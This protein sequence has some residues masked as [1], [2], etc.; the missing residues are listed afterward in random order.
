M[1]NQ[2]IFDVI[3]I[4]GGI[5]GNAVADYI[6]Q[7]SKLK[8]LLLEQN[9]L[10]TGST[11]FSASLVTKLR[12]ETNLIPFIEETHHAVS[13]LE[14]VHGESLGERR[15]GCLHVA[16][17]SDS[18]KELKKLKLIADESGI[19][20]QTVD[21]EFIRDRVPWMVSEKVKDALFVPDEFFIDG[22]LL[23]M[24][25]FK[26][27][28]LNGL[29]Y[30]T[31]CK[32]IRIISGNNK[33]TGVESDKGIYSAPIIIDTAGIWTNLLLKEHDVLLPYAPVRSLYFITEVNI[34]N[35]PVS[36]PICIL[37]DANAFSRPET[38]ALLIGLR[39]SQSPWTHPA[40]IQKDMSNQKSITQNEQWNILI[41]ETAGLSSIMKDFEHLK[42]AHAIAAPCAY[43]HDGNP[44]L[45][46]VKQLEGLFVAT[47]CNGAGISTSAGFGRVIAEI[48]LGK[49]PFVSINDY[50]PARLQKSHPFSEEFMQKCSAR[51]SR[52]KSG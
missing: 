25:F 38:G 36:Q 49:E 15:V 7:N 39:D 3:I 19:V 48:V 28:R 26:S 32:V 17:D 10:C 5:L 47:G 34:E 21:K 33:I 37:P 31:N 24:A 22:Y 18:L 9:Q 4:G 29:I 42:I 11:S 50:N 41:N 16:S 12:H 14:K 30:K 44:L 46:S 6:T 40:E 1:K 45:G 23:G 35:Y 27:A 20:S 51:R 2:N 43:T 13:R 52:K 8:I